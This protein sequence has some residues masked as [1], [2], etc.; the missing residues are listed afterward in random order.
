MSVHP[1]SGHIFNG[2]V[3]H[4]TKKYHYKFANPY[5]SGDVCAAGLIPYV[6]RSDGTTW[7]LFQ[8]EDMK[9]PEGWVPAV[10]MF[11]GKVSTG[12]RDWRA[13]AAREFAEETG[14]LLDE[15]D[16]CDRIANSTGQSALSVYVPESKYQVM[17]YPVPTEYHD[18][19]EGLPDKYH[20]TFKGNIV[21]WSRAATRLLCIQLLYDPERG[22]TADQHGGELPNKVELNG[23]LSRLM[24]VSLEMPV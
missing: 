24:L 9:K 1:L 21:K 12:D 7:G 13:T 5:G 22:W 11:G 18:V 10:A 17:F 14:G 4:P 3:P 20:Q 6:V 15:Y 19:V 23:A 2:P 8:I 16:I